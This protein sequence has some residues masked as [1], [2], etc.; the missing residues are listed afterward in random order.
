ML[1]TNRIGHLAQGVKEKN[2]SQWSVYEVSWKDNFPKACFLRHLLVMV[3]CLGIKSGYLYPSK[4]GLTN[5]QLVRDGISEEGMGYKCW[6]GWFNRMLKTACRHSGESLALWGA[7]TPRRTFYLLGVLGG[8]L[9]EPLMRN[10]RH[11]CPRTAKGYFEDAC[12]TRDFILSEPEVA[13]QQMIWPFRDKLMANNGRTNMRIHNYCSDRIHVTSLAVVAKR[14]VET[15]LGVG[16]NHRHY[17]DPGHLLEISFTKSFSGTNPF[18]DFHVIADTLPPHLK[19]P[20]KASFQAALAYRSSQDRIRFQKEEAAG[21]RIPAYTNI[22]S[23][24]F[25][26]PV[27]VLP[28]LP[29]CRWVIPLEQQP[30]G[31]NLLQYTIHPDL[32]Q[33]KRKAKDSP[34]DTALLLFEVV[35]EVLLVCPGTEQEPNMRYVGG[36]RSLRRRKEMFSRYL[37]QFFYCLHGCHN[38]DIEKF[39][40]CNPKYSPEEYNK[41]G[42]CGSCRNRA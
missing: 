10:G 2:D 13:A 11:L 6:T 38:M 37:N 41:A 8:A 20:I 34:R 1:K 15:Q 32:S 5:H 36:R 42:G 21:S 25:V 4:D 9:F 35:Q 22:A 40:E 33:H 19:E 18:T 29:R 7:H 28:I 23:V 12:V 30:S 24:N 17:K 16:P 3:H 14:F 27:P 26:P 31:N 39:I